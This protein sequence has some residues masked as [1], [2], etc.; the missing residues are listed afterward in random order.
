MVKGRFISLNI[1]VFIGIKQALDRAGEYIFA[2]APRG[3]I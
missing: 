2:F 1:S 3:L